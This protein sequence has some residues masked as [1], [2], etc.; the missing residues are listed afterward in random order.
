MV[1]RLLRPVYPYA[2][3]MRAFFLWLSRSQRLKHLSSEF[4]PFW[5]MASR[6]VAGSTL[7]DA[8][9]VIRQLN[10]EGLKVT[11]D[12]LG[13]NTTNEQEAL[14]AADAYIEALERIHR[15]GVDSGVSIK[16][17]QMGL[18]LSYEFT[19]N[20]V[21]RILQTAQRLGNFVRIDMES[22]AYTQQTLDLYE[23]FH[24]KYGA[25]HVGIVIQAYLRRSEQDIRHIIEMGGNVRLCKGAYLEPPEIAFPKKSQVDENFKHLL[26][27]LLHRD[28]LKTGTYTAVATHDEK[29]IAHAKKLERERNIPRDRFE[30]QML[31]GIRNDLQRKLAREGYTVRVYVP[32]GT[33]WYPYFM[34]RLA[35]RPANVFFILKNLFR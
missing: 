25:R 32:Y 26:N 10:Q 1:A 34:R 29:M 19:L 3:M 14:A 20:N 17:T 9:R 21:D 35:E 28:A 15:E 13:E 22:S 11:L 31:Y 23:H 27:L 16:L 18:D 2:V 30:F 24:K 12:H 4:Q 5:K 33:E 6:F 7:D 8:I